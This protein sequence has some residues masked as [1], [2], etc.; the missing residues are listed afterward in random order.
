MANTIARL[1]E[2]WP[3]EVTCLLAFLVL[4]RVIWKVDM[5]ETAS[6][7]ECGWP[8]CDGQQCQIPYACRDS[9]RR[10]GT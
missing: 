2:S 4:V 8:S 7:G 10:P 5:Q 3:G 1:L 9:E 6:C